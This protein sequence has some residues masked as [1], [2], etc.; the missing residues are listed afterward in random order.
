MKAIGVVAL[1][2]V[3]A[4]WA[5]GSDFDLPSLKYDQ[6]APGSLPSAPASGKKLSDIPSFDLPAKLPVSV[7]NEQISRD[8]IVRPPTDT[9]YKLR[10]LEAPKVDQGILK[11]SDSKR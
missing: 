2:M 5:F 6:R 10:I 1:V 9:D 8:G 11:N 7:H 4:Q 3:S